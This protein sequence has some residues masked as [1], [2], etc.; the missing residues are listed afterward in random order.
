MCYQNRLWDILNSIPRFRRYKLSPQR[1]C[2]TCW[3]ESKSR[4][5]PIEDMSV[6]AAQQ[7]DHVTNHIFLARFSFRKDVNKGF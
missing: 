7:I 4:K 1:S 6:T 5:S 2:I 3:F